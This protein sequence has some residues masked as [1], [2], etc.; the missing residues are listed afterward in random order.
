MATASLRIAPIHLIWA[1]ALAACA[2]RAA[3]TTGLG[4]TPTVFV[5]D[6]LYLGRG[7]PG[8]GEVSDSALAAFMREVVT[9]RFPDGL[10]VFHTEGQWR[11][12]SGEVV[13]ERGLVLEIMHPRGQPGDS[14]IQRVATEYRVRFNQDAVL[15]SSAEV[16]VLL[17]MR[18]PAGGR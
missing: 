13:R 5:A 17:Y 4:P 9:P 10:T 18:P 7:I 16:R 14:L 11:D 6:R 3:V 15:R 8:G 12:P 2:P 1:L